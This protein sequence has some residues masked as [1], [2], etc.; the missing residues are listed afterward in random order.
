MYN[1]ISS[2]RVIFIIQLVGLMIFII[3]R[4][5]INIQ[6]PKVVNIHHKPNY[7][8]LS[9]LLGFNVK[10][11]RFKGFTLRVVENLLKKLE[12]SSHK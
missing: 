6:M 4:M 10:E 12:A 7:Y 11:Q 9:I 8:S 5:N 3:L 2:I 1:R